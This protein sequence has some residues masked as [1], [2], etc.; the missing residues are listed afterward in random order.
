MDNNKLESRSNNL[1]LD[2]EVFRKLGYDLIDK[3][4]EFLQSFEE[5]KVTSGES[6]SQIRKHF[7]KIKPFTK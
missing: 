5:R 1:D 7:S 3:L 2:P 4:T 6:P